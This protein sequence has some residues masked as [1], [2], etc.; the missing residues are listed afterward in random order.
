MG[1]WGVGMQAN[2]SALDWIPHVEVSCVS[3]GRSYKK[4]R[5]VCESCGECKKCCPCDKPRLSPAIKVIERRDKGANRVLLRA[6]KE[7]PMGA[8]GVAEHMLDRGLVIKPSAKKA[9]LKV[10]K[11]ELSG[12]RL[13]CWKN[14][15]E[16]QSALERFRERV[17]TGKYSEL[18]RRVD[19]IGLLDRFA[20][21]MEGKGDR[22]SIKK[23]ISPK[24]RDP[25]VSQ[26]QDRLS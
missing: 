15:E 1:S 8:L 10:I 11:K 16:R 22:E 17:N 18:E 12:N 4:A 24:T 13:D 20:L 21:E 19:N 3:C 26:H 6:C 14:P 7:E 25:K 5:T 9:I 23:L 2:D